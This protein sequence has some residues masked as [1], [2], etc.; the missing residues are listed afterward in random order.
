MV[1]LGR[2]GGMFWK[3]G[4]FAAIGLAAAGCASVPLLGHPQPSTPPPPPPSEHVGARCG[5][6]SPCAPKTK[7]PQR[8]YFD[9]RHQRY[10]YYDPMT[11]RYY[12]E[13]GQ[14]KV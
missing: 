10:Y 2:D 4:A 3:L 12:W 11:R 13:D 14:P 7:S 6:G 5:P 1:D 9:L 8:Q